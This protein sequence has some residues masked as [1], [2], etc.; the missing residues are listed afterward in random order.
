MKK[1]IIILGLM[2]TI[3]RADSAIKV[4][5]NSILFWGPNDPSEGVT[6]Y[7]V[8]VSGGPGLLTFST[9][10][11]NLYFGVFMAN[12]GN[13]DYTLWVTA[14]GTG[15]TSDNSNVIQVKYFDKPNPPGINVK[16]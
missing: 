8:N 12:R 2:T 16:P 7:V 1:L 14:Q 10:S 9:T 6:N 5:K 11:T 4:A 3:I 15:G 13:G